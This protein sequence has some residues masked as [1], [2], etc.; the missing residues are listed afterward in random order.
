[1]GS[2]SDLNKEDIKKNMPTTLTSVKPLHVVDK[3]DDC[4]LIEGFKRGNI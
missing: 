4:R 2:R 1:M 3:P